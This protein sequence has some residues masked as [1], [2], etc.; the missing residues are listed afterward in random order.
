M[1]PPRF[2]CGSSNINSPAAREAREAQ[3]GELDRETA[4]AGDYF[5]QKCHADNPKFP[6]PDALIPKRDRTGKA[7]V[8]LTGRHSGTP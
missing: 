5:V 4:T 8:R 2:T 6:R 7:R 3:E 1:A